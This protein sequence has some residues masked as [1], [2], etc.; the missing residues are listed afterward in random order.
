MKVHSID[1]S[2]LSA[3][4]DGTAYLLPSL[5]DVQKHYQELSSE[6][7]RH[8]R[9]GRKVVVVQGLGFVGAAVAAV[10]AGK[11]RPDGEPMYFV[12]GVD[13]ALSSSF[14]K[15]G[16]INDGECPYPSPDREL[17]GL[18][19]S[20]VLDRK[21]L[22]ATVSEEVYSLADI[23]VVDVPL[24]VTDVT[25]KDP[26][27]LGVDITSFEAAIRVIGR[28]MKGSALVIVE[29]T[30]PIGTVTKIVL[31]ILEQERE[32]RGITQS[33]HLAHVYERVMP[34]PNY[35][36]SI[37]RFWRTFSGIDQDSARQAREFLESFVD[38]GSYPLCELETP[39]HS[40]MAKLLENS[41]RA[42]NI[43]F[44]H[45]W[46]MMAE[47][48]GVNLFAI[49]D[50]IRVRKGTHDNIRYP[51]FGV[52]GYCLPKDPMLAQWSLREFFNSELILGTTMQ[53]LEINR[54][55]PLHTLQL[56]TQLVGAPL[57]G[58]KVV[59]C[60]LAYLPGVPDTRNSPTETLVDELEKTGAKILVHDPIVTRWDERPK[61]KLT[62]D[63]GDLSDSDAIVFA[64][65]HRIYQE[66]DVD[67]LLQ[68]T[69]SRPVIVDAQNILSDSK[70]SILHAAG[71][72][73]VGV[74]K[75]HWRTRGFHQVTI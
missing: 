43:A 64:V 69:R 49:I 66:L 7:L 19:S 58:R 26:K 48:M 53:A 71:C 6:A 37:C 56:L 8:Q 12:I 25:E 22:V 32:R 16:K 45:E 54:K 50:S 55:M 52:G 11:N 51:G 27:N 73:I 75:G 31:P 15:V 30:V 74:G 33:I 20:T 38:V 61:V 35:T 41:Y 9:Q 34:G 3:A 44:I 28:S 62:N 60:G 24:N 36:G 47:V 29:T 39:S 40:E 70:A 23:I 65:P 57:A 14:W 67:G 72:R 21:N 13:M 46:T 17:M 1:G 68:I 42:V 59:V 2:N 5:A 10:V 63:L 4:P 18:F